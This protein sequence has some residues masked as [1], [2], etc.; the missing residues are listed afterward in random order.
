VQYINQT[1]QFNRYRASRAIHIDPA[2]GPMEKQR[3]EIERDIVN[4]RWLADAAERVGELLEESLSALHTGATRA[5]TAKAAHAGAP[6]LVVTGAAPRP[7]WAVVHVDTSTSGLGTARDLSRP[8][9]LGLNPL[10]HMLARLA[11]CERLAGVVL[12]ATDPVEARRLVG[13]R[14]EIC[15]SRSSRLRPK[16]GA[17][18]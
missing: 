4:V 15:A 3:K 17:S 1:G 5:N 2:L 11:R 18:T 7:I 8:F 9:L 14:P 6:A 10:Q 13:P 12:L 16:H